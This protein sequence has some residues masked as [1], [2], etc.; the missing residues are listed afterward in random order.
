M[1]TE[2][3]QA[4]R[5]WVAGWSWDGASYLRL[6]DFAVRAHSAGQAHGEKRER[7]R[8][9]AW[10]QEKTKQEFWTA[11]DLLVEFLKEKQV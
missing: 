6:D 7:E 11:R 3:E 2:S 4:A 5:E 9:I 1:T 10:W 8:T